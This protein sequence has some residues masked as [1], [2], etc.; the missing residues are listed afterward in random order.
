VVPVFDPGIGQGGLQPLRVRPGVLGTAYPAALA[1]VQ[2]LG[3]P[4]RAQ[5]PEERLERET[6][7]A[8]GCYPGHVAVSVTAR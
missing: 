2:E 7:H 6:V 4:V 5:R 1:N 3:H 8:D